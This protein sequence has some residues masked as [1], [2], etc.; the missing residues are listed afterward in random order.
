MNQR[1]LAVTFVA[2]LLIAAGLI[3]LTVHARE[4]VSNLESESRRLADLLIP[5]AGLLP[6]AFGA[7]LLLGRGWARYLAVA[8]MAVIV[9]LSFVDNWQKVV[10]HSILLALIAFGLFRR[11]AGVYFE[12]RKAAAD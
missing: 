5:M 1:P 10:I 12:Q 9:A 2:W 3:A 11:D 8:Y 4:L 7:F 6:V